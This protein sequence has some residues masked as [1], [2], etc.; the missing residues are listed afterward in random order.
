[1]LSMSSQSIEMY[2]SCGKSMFPFLKED[3]ILIIKKVAPQ[4]LRIGDLV[5]F[6]SPAGL[7]VAHRLVKKTF[8]PD[9]SVLLQAKGDANWCYDQPFG[10]DDLVGKVYLIELMDKTGKVKTIDL[11]IWFRRVHNFIIAK[12]SVNKLRAYYLLRKIFRKLVKFIN[13]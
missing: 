1:M 13:S 3:A 8:L 2:K 12:K 9:N 10:I 11:Q 5:V 7:L 6:K 4:A